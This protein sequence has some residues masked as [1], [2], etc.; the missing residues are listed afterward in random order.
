MLEMSRK[1]HRQDPIEPSS[2]SGGSFSLC[3]PHQ[4]PCLFRVGWAYVLL[5]YL[6]LSFGNDK[7]APAR[8]PALTAV[9]I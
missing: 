2:R 4:G 7:F 9:G 1:I 8:T 3:G 6:Q 5:W